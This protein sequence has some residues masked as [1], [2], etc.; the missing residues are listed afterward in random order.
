MKPPAILRC[1]SYRMRN[2]IPEETN[3][4][5]LNNLHIIPL[6]GTRL[7]LRRSTGATGSGALLGS[8]LPRCS[9]SRGLRFSFRR[10]GDFL[11]FNFP[12]DL[13]SDWN[14]NNC[15]GVGACIGPGGERAN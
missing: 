12:E 6:T 2:A 1:A 14:E 9:S 5:K 13:R 4:L 7:P 8:A 15:S 3:L 10:C 11:Q